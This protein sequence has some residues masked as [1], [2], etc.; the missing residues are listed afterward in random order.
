MDD[1]KL[2][3]SQQDTVCVGDGNDGKC[4]WAQN[5]RALVRSAEIHP[6]YEAKM[7]FIPRLGG[8]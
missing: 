7:S 5:R 6:D 3:A 8:V 2:H 4:S 1:W